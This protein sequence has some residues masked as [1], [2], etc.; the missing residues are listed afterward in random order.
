MFKNTY[1]V[2]ENAEQNNKIF[3]RKFFFFIRN[4]NC[5]LNWLSKTNVSVDD[6][7]Y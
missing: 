2:L 5:T 3:Y 7:L 6:F 1:K 4:R